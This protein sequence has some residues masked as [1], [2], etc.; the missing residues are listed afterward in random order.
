M[1]HGD[2]NGGLPRDLHH[3]VAL[4]R[5]AEPAM[6]RA[7]PIKQEAGTGLLHMLI[8]PKTHLPPRAQLKPRATIP[9]AWTNDRKYLRWTSMF[10]HGA[11]S[12]RRP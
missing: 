5:S 7:A 2:T 12:L 6:D 9:L 1:Y 11:G 4:L 3:N 8:E 10:A